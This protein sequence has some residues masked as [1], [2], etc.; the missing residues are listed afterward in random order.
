MG[1]EW[2][3]EGENWNVRLFNIVADSES[4]ESQP[5]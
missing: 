1:N 3:D 4:Q 2:V 5:L